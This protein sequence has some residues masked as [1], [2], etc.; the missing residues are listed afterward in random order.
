LKFQEL[1]AIKRLL[2]GQIAM[3]RKKNI[4]D[5]SRIYI[6]AS[7][8]IAGHLESLANLGIHGNTASEVAKHLVQNEVERL[9]KEGFLKLKQEKK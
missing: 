4:N 3:S 6:R 5:T 8:Q 2:S 1:C 7:S 9:V